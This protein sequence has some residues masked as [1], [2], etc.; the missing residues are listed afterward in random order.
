MIIV[1]CDNTVKNPYIKIELPSG[2]RNY[3]YRTID[4]A[5]HA[6]NQE[7][8]KLSSKEI[9]VFSYYQIVYPDHLIDQVFGDYLLANHPELLL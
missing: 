2:R 7:E 8:P 5:L 3:F 1:L 9:T 6:D 4:Y